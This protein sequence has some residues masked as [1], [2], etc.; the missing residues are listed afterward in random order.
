MQGWNGR[1]LIPS[2]G[3]FSG[4]SRNGHHPVG[5][6]AQVVEHTLLVISIGRFGLLLDNACHEW[7]RENFVEKLLN[8]VIMTGEPVAYRYNLTF[9]PDAGFAR[10]RVPVTAGDP[11]KWRQVPSRCG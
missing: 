11:H 7:L 8:G 4:R 3:E 10:R 1:G 6:I 2:S 9:C 5:C